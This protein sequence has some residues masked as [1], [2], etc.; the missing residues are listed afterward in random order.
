VS[1]SK[2][3]INFEALVMKNALEELGIVLDELSI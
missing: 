2:I 1:K 3:N